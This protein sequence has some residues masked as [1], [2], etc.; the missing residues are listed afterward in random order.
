M[1]APF[2]LAGTKSPLCPRVSDLLYII[3][4]RVDWKDKPAVLHTLVITLSTLLK[5]YRDIENNNNDYLQMLFLDALE[6]AFKWQEN[7]NVPD[8]WKS[9]LPDDEDEKDDDDGVDDDEN[10]E[11]VRYIFPC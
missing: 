4:F 10:A 1:Y 6:N 5:F 3:I 2:R 7:A 8:A 11:K 9:E